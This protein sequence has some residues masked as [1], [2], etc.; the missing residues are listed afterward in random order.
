MFLGQPF[1]LSGLG[2]DERM[3][4]SGLFGF[5]RRLLPASKSGMFGTSQLTDA[6]LNELITAILSKYAVVKSSRGTS[7]PDAV[8]ADIRGI[9]IRVL[10]SVMAYL[11]SDDIKN[12]VDNLDAQGYVIL[13]VSEVA[14][15]KRSVQSQSPSD[16]QKSSSAVD[17]AIDFFRGVIPLIPDKR[18]VSSKPVFVQ[19]SRPVWPMAALVIGA[20]GVIGVSIYLAT[21]E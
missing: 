15:E 1:F 3:T 4:A 13:P 9:V 10:G 2:G 11:Y 12:A 20:V 18:K 6:K 21:R 7:N 19:Q 8:T 16:A 5:M 17:A 14:S